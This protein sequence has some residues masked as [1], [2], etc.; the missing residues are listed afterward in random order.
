MEKIWIKL[1]KTM[2]IFIVCMY[3]WNQPI[4]NKEGIS[5]NDNEN[6]KSKMIHK[7]AHTRK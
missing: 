7:T 2:S 5:Q 4:I 1:S 3:F 6:Q